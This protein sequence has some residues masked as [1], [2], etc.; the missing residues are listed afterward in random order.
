VRSLEAL[1]RLNHPRYG[2]ISPLTVV[3]TA[4]ETGLIEQLGQWVLEH[5]CLQMRTWM[6]QG[7]RLV[8]VAINVSSLQLMRRG[9]AER[10]METVVR[11]PSMISAPVTLHS[12]GFTNCQ[13]PS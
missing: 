3:Q 9:F 13:S 1:L 2:A 7:V 10:L 12:K 11:S 5:A 8:P 6:D 4:E